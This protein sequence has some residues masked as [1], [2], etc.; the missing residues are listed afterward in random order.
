MLQWRGKIYLDILYVSVKLLIISSCQKKKPQEVSTYE[1]Q[2]NDV[3]IKN[4][5]KWT[6]LSILSF[7]L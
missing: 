6:L 2:L 5:L 1:K 3:K 4:F 7:N